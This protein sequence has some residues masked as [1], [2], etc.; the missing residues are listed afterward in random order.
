MNQAIRSVI[1]ITKKEYLNGW[2]T[3]ERLF[4]AYNHNIQTSSNRGADSVIEQYSHTHK[5]TLRK[6]TRK[7]TENTKEQNAIWV[8]FTGH[9]TTIVEL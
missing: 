8:L 9:D 2:V 4:Q 6:K 5:H 1:D 7:K 3:E